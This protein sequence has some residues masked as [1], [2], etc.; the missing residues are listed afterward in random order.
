MET[1]KLSAEPRSGSG[2]GSARQLRIAGKIPGV[3]YYRGQDTVSFKTDRAEFETLLRRRPSLITLE[4]KGFDARECVIREIQRDPVTERILHVDLLGIKR[5]QKLKVN[6]PIRLTG[7]PLGVRS[8]GGI[9]QHSLTEVEIECLPK[10]IPPFI[11]VNVADLQIGDTIHLS[12]LSIQDIKIVD[13]P[14]I[15]VANVVEPVISRVEEV[16]AEAAE[17]DEETE[18][19][20][21]ESE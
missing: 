9:L 8:G 4:V 19:T 10:D 2:K 12:D 11:E 21:E 3:F 15:V 20:E 6:V 13:D 16:E 17:A 14:Q 7:I 18:H 5:G 1:N